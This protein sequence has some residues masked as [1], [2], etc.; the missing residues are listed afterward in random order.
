[1]EMGLNK[2]SVRDYKKLL[3][4]NP[5]LRVKYWKINHED[6]LISRIF[7]KLAQVPFLEELFSHDIYAVLEKVKG[8]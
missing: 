8:F 1:M 2:L 5:A 3:L 7:A 4:E 6:R